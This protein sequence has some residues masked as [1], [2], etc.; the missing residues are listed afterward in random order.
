LD[1]L[2]DALNEPGDGPGD[3]H[4]GSELISVQALEKAA[5]DFVSVADDLDDFR[6]N[7]FFAIFDGL[8]R[9]N[10]A[11]TQGGGRL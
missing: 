9:L 11:R 5:A 7:T 1:D 2:I 3:A 4:S 10:S 6:D 8:I